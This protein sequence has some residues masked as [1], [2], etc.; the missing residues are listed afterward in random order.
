MQVTPAE[1]DAPPQAATTTANIIRA[2]I[3]LKIT[4]AAAATS[5]R[6]A[7]AALFITMTPPASSKSMAAS[8]TA[9]VG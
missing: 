4:G 1:T 2:M 3:R 8:T 7:A 9:A 6:T 5:T